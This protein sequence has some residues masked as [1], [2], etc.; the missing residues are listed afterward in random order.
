MNW[1]TLKAKLYAAGA[2]LIGVLAFFL[3]LKVVTHQ[4]D[5]AKEKAKRA[6]AQAKEATA[7]VEADAEI[8]EEFVELE[9]ESEEAI[10]KGEM[11]DHMR[12]RNTF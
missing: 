10:E 1:L 6:T 5:V 8:E 9:Q 11:P 12:E 2:V 4:R 3:R 7:I